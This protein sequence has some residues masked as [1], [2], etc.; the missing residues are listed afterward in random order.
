MYMALSLFTSKYMHTH[1][2]K[3][4]KKYVKTKLTEVQ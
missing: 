2:T 4:E 1:S 3:E